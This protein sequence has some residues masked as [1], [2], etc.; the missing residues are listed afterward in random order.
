MILTALKHS[1]I[2][3]NGFSQRRNLNKLVKGKL[4]PIPAES[5]DL[6][7]WTSRSLCVLIDQ[8]QLLAINESRYWNIQMYKCIGIARLIVLDLMNA[9]MPLGIRIWDLK[10]NEYRELDL[11]KGHKWWE[12][13]SKLLTC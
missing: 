7:S 13:Q 6:S 1:N 12:Q 2:I 5:V 8:K 10:L 11:K 3:S 4:I 9:A